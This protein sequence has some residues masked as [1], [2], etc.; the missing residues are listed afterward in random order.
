LVK[1]A[2]LGEKVLFWLKNAI[3]GEKCYLEWKM[4]C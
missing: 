2:I 1:N 4:L 3:L